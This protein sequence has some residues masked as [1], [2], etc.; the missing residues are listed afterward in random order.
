MGDEL[1]GGRATPAQLRAFGAAPA[2][3]TSSQTGSVTFQIAL[4]QL[5][6]LSLKRA[7]SAIEQQA[8]S[9]I[10]NLS[11]SASATTGGLTGTVTLGLR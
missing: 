4:P 6:A 1:L 7:P 10:G 8:L 3:G 5:L 2:N 11:G 9:V